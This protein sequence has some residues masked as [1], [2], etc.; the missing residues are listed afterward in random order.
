VWGFSSGAPDW[1]LRAA[2]GPLPATIERFAFEA[3]IQ[4]V[5]QL[6]EI[7]FCCVAAESQQVFLDASVS[8]DDDSQDPSVPE[9]NH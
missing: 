7:A 8:C 2:S 6:L 3:S 1:V 4:I 5:D 9:R